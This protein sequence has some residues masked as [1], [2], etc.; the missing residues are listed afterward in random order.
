MAFDSII[1]Y[2]SYISLAFRDTWL[3]LKHGG[4]WI[5]YRDKE[6]RP[7]MKMIYQQQKPPDGIEAGEYKYGIQIQYR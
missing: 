7:T 1:E 3:F 4:E 5:V 6:T 2:D